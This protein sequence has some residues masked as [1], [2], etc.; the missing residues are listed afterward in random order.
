LDLE[1][2]KIIGCIGAFLLF[3]SLFTFTVAF[4]FILLIGSILVLISLYG[5]AKF[6]QDKEIF[7]NALYG[8][9]TTIIGAV[10]TFVF[11]LASPIRST[12]TNNIYRY[13]PDWNGNYANLAKGITTN[14]FKILGDTISQ[15]FGA[16]VVLIFIVFWVFVI[17]AMLF[18]RR[19]MKKLSEH[20]HH[21]AF[22]NTG[23]VII[24]SAAIPL[25]GLIGLWISTLLLALAFI[26]TKK[27]NPTSLSTNLSPS[28]TTTTPNTE[29]NCCPY[30]NTPTLPEASFCALC[31]KQI[32]RNKNEN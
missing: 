18:M 24:I 15:R 3:L 28:Q 8:T 19:S 25:I 31:G 32:Q 29:T 4:G 1:T 6:Y 21:I 17:I 27:P 13:V 12:L 7:N 30:C 10:I 5:L 16:G 11:I 2:S 14:W 23:T 26:N 22:T 9:L 20:S